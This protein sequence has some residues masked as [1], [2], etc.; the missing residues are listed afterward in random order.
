MPS[1]GILIF[2]SSYPSSLDGALLNSVA[3]LT[4]VSDRFVSVKLLLSLAI[5]SASVRVFEI[6]VRVKL[7]PE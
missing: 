1:L 3:Q 4:T 7:M 2:I 5:G 6:L